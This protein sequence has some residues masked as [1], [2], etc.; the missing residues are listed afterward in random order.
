M[1]FY[2]LRRYLLQ[3]AFSPFSQTA[4]RAGASISLRYVASPCVMIASHMSAALCVC[5]HLF[6]C[7]AVFVSPPVLV[8]ISST[9]YLLLLT[10]VLLRFYSLSF[11]LLFLGVEFAGVLFCFSLLNESVNRLHP[12]T[13]L[14]LNT[15]NTVNTTALCSLPPKLLVNSGNCHTLDYIRITSWPCKQIETLLLLLQTP[16]APSCEMHSSFQPPHISLF[17]Q[18]A[19]PYAVKTIISHTGCAANC[20]YDPLSGNLK[21]RRC[22]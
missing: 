9:V 16:P 5:P 10:G 17:L 14:L 12:F 19:P 4:V 2:P 13:M 6:D 20:V 15:S 11:G 8:L 3:I 22:M 21:S 18:Q 1:H 7:P